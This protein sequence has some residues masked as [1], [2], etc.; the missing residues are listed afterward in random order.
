MACDSS[1]C[2]NESS[3]M[4]LLLHLSNT[5]LKLFDISAFNRIEFQQN[6]NDIRNSSSIFSSDCFIFK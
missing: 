2:I 1:L 3:C 6:V 5:L 4:T